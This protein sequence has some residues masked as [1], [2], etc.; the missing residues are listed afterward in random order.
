MIEY[1][2]C[3]LVELKFDGGGDAVTG[4]RFKGYGAVFGNVDKGGDLIE[5]GAFSAFLADMRAG[6]QEW[7]AMLSQHGAMGMT[8]QDMTPVGVWHNLGEDGKGLD[9]EGEFADT[10]RGIELYK[11]GKMKPRPALKGLSIGYI[12]KESTPR[13]KPD[14]PSRRLKRIDL[15]EISPV[16]FPANGKARVSA[17]KSIEELT[18]LRDAEEV[19]RARGFSKTEAVAFVARIKGIGPGDPVVLLHGCGQ[20]A[21]GF[22]A[23]TG[24]HRVADR[25]RFVVLF[26]EQDRLAN[27]QG[28]W[29]WFDK[30]HQGHAGEPAMIAAM[31]RQIAQAHGVDGR[32]G[33]DAQ[34]G[35]EPPPH[36]G[37]THPGDDRRDPGEDELQERLHGCITLSL[38]LGMGG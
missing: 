38:R 18:S 26:P 9:T 20:D 22:A 1:T 12:A 2:S 21:A 3:G 30:A 32:D 17:V 13:T 4:M 5:P 24:M 25:G 35:D 34:G 19:L 8:A 6:K 29:N 7:P 15:I 16:T 10:E 14:E 11:L 27:A 23:V 33:R 28:C 37:Q 31:T 36:E